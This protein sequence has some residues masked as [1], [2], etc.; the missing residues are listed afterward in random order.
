MSSLN[1]TADRAQVLLPSKEQCALVRLPPELLQIIID[2][3][4]TSDLSAVGRTCRTLYELMRDDRF[5][6][7]RIRSQFPPSIAHLYTFELFLK[8]EI[9]PSHNEIRP[10]GFLHTRNDDQFDLLAIESATHYNDQAIEQRS[11]KMF[12]SRE[13]FVNEVDFYQFAKP[14]RTAD[15]A[16]MKLVYFYLI[17]RKRC[18]TVD[19]GVIHRNDQ[20]LV[21]EE[22]PDSLTGRIIHLERVCW[23]EISGRLE[24]KLM[25]G[26]YEV[27]WR[28]RERDEDVAI[29]GTTEFIA[30][31][32][33][34]KLLI[35][36]MLLDDFR[37]LRLEHGS[38]WFTVRMGHIVI[39]EPSAVLFAIRNWQ[40]R[41]WKRGVSW[42]CI[43]FTLIP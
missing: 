33:H 13:E 3:L 25:P 40:H 6:I 16:M 39:Y 30:V 22:E 24:K 27:S 43:E 23:L 14:D 12:V 32:Q 31:P 9:I 15:V 21:E 2:H 36:H 28:M 37:S 35:Y 34:G 8:P 7:Q 29:S 26:K 42:D 38:D 20:Y 41:F 19:M 4:N 10:S 1:P 5:W 11:A 17:D 18:A